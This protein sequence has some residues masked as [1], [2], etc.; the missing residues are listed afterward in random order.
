MTTY[1]TP[2]PLHPAI[3]A[4]TATVTT[5]ALVI[6][7]II[8]V[9]IIASGTRAGAAEFARLSRPEYALPVARQP[10]LL[11]KAR[12]RADLLRAHGHMDDCRASQ[13]GLPMKAAV[14]AIVLIAAATPALADS[15]VQRD[16][17]TVRFYNPNGST[18]GSATTYGNTTKF[19]A[20]DGKLTGSATRNGSK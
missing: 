10:R 8:L 4:A 17:P 19:Y 3:R 16:A 9:T 11:Q 2:R 1:Q 7:T 5:V 13:E 14:T 12:R 6:F 18:A 15:T 20:P